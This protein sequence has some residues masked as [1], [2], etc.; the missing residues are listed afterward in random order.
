MKKETNTTTKGELLQ[1]IW[2]VHQKEQYDKNMCPIPYY[3]ISKEGDMFWLAHVRSKDEA[4][5][6]CQAVNERQKLLDEN[7]KMY[8][9]LCFANS[10]LQLSKTG[11]YN[12]GGQNLVDTKL[13]ISVFLNNA[14]NIQP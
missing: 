10:S 9:I 8:D 5:Q 3:E 4:D 13:K 12:A 6:I 1:D 2:R 11:L 7:K 14:K